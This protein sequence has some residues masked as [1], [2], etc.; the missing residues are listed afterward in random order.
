M[1]DKLHPLWYSPFLPVFFFMTAIAAGLAI[2]IFESFMSARAF[3]KKLEHDLLEGL[4][5]VIV[6]VLAVYAV[7]KAQDL[8][9]RGHLHLVLRPTFE[10]V[11]FWGEM[12]LG[13]LLPMLLFSLPAVRRSEQGLFLAAMLTVMGFV[14]NRLN[15]S[16]TGME[17]WSQARYFPS[18]MEIAVTMSIVTVGFI[19]FGLAAR[20]LPVF[21]DEHSR[22]ESGARVGVDSPSILGDSRT[23]LSLPPPSRAKPAAGGR[24]LVALW[25]LLAVGVIAAGYSS[26]RAPDRDAESAS[27]VDSASGYRIDPTS[28]TLP[29][30]YV[31]PH[32]ADSLAPVTFSHEAH[33]DRANLECASCHQ[34]LFRMHAP[35]TPLHGKPTPERMHLKLCGS[36]HN[37]KEAFSIDEGC[38][39]CHA[40]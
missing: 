21:S 35:G 7:W 22:A 15:V 2:T 25:S 20:H 27:P 11:L 31:F 18:W 29:A 30:D 1:P 6:V 34:S 38:A 14:I 36:C 37:G 19:L 9:G 8:A 5:R 33:L 17:G 32:S 39:R 3:G 16:I 28:I 40:K 10:S 13:V 4:G 23:E 26:Q 24:A 12:G